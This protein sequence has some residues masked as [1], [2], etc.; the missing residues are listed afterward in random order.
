MADV[1]RVSIQGVLPGGEKWS[2][3]PCYQL[4]DSSDPV[5]FSELN[6][7]ADA[8]LALVPGTNMRSMWSTTTNYNQVRLEARSYGG[9]LEALLEKPRSSTV[10]GTGGQANPFQ[11]SLV[12]SLRSVTP[13]GRGRGRLYWPATGISIAAATLRPS[14]ALIG[15]ILADVKT[16]L[17]GISAA[18]TPTLGTNH[19]VVWSRTYPG[20]HQVTRI[21]MGDVLDVQR[22]RRDSLAESY[23]EVVYP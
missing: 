5:T 7:V 4:I 14:G 17:S 23:S 11:T 6:T 9:A 20:S 18:I 12:S 16:F 13:G 15:P 2:V 10:V 8:I 19:L 21:L 3:N 22:R 1:L